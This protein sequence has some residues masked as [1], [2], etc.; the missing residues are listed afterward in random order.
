MGRKLCGRLKRRLHSGDMQKLH[1]YLLA[2]QNDLRFEVRR[3]GDAFVYYR[4]GKALEIRAQK[5]DRKYGDTPDC[6][7]SITD[8]EL[9]FNKIRKVI[10]KWL[11]KKQRPEFDTQQSVAIANSSKNNDYIII[12]MEYSFSLAFLPK[13]ERPK[14]IG[15]DLIGIERESGKLCIFE[16]KTGI[17]AIDG[18]SGVEQHINDFEEYFKGKYSLEFKNNIC[19]DVISI[20]SDKTELGYMEHIDLPPDFKKIEPELIFV[21]EERTIGDK[22]HIENVVRG[23]HKIIEVGTDKGYK[24]CK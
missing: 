4:K 6:S 3:G 16:V 7:L 18:K 19:E 15:F 2:N 17:G 14:S 1:N 13:G 21:F 22:N 10:D 24:L 5:V 11:V 12:D 9:Y 8:P 20:L 23:R